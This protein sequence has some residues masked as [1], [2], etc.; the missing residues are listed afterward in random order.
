M[1]KSVILLQLLLGPVLLYGL[2]VKSLEIG[3]SAPDFTL[4]GIDGRNWSLH[5]FDQSTLLVIIFT[6]N[7]CPTAQA[8]EKKMI[9]LQKAYPVSAVQVVAISP[10]SPKVVCLEELGYSDL[11]DSF[12]EMVIRAKDAGFSFPYLYDGDEQLV[13][14]AYGPQATPHVFIFDRERH[15][16]YSGRFDD[17]EN[18]YITPAHSDAPAAIAA[19]LAGK[20]ISEPRTRVFGCSVKWLE[21]EDWRQKMDEEWS[22]REVTLQPADEKTL[23]AIRANGSGN[24]RLIN[25]WATWCGP[26]IMEFPELVKIHRMYRNR[27]FEVISI[28]SDLP[29][30]SGDVLDFLKKQDAAFPNYIFTGENKD[31]LADA[32]NPDWA[33]NIPLTLLISPDGQLL[34]SHTGLIDPYELKKLIINQLGRYYADN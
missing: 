31:A 14:R 25:V 13:A 3:S 19:L 4:P 7:H 24:Y 6:A 12:S 17:T 2:D 23:A 18:P 30:K 5:D 16:R 15:L 34:Y 10:N 11:G 21:K 1:K 8:Y 29:Q 20:E 27:K 33:G 28:S 9:D 32:L 22:M 26:C